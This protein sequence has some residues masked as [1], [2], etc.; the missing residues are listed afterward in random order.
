MKD[1]Y[2]VLG[3]PE[4]IRKE[5]LKRAF[6]ILA[7]QHHPD[8]TAGNEE[9]F[10]E[11]TEAYRVLLGDESRTQYDREFKEYKNKKTEHENSERKEAPDSPNVPTETLYKSPISFSFLAVSICFVLAAAFFISNGSGEKTSDT[12]MQPAPPVDEF[13]TIAQDAAAPSVGQT[14]FPMNNP[15]A[16]SGWYFENDIPRYRHCFVYGSCSAEE[17]ALAVYGDSGDPRG[18]DLKL[19]ADSLKAAYTSQFSGK[20]VKEYGVSICDLSQSI[21]QTYDDGDRLVK[22]EGNEINCVN[23]VTGA[24][25]QTQGTTARVGAANMYCVSDL[26]VVY[27]DLTIQVV[28]SYGEINDLENS[29]NYST[30]QQHRTCVWTYVDGNGAVPYLLVSGS[31]GPASGYGVRAFC[32]NFD[33]YVYVYSS[34]E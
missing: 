30:P 34:K 32:T 18:G 21:V 31:L 10:K 20:C 28:K 4:S 17:W 33:N 6:R 15:D 8:R 14:D 5:E 27:I 1:Y 11:I 7:H 22:L 24:Q 9:R 19:Q 26:G 25:R 29:S 12:S 23:A 13:G 3:V 2:D 16:Q